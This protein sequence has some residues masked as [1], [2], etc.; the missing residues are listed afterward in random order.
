V[1]LAVGYR[2]VWRRYIIGAGA[3][4]SM[5]VGSEI[6]T[7]ISFYFLGRFDNPLFLKRDKYD[8]KC[9]ANAC[10]VPGSSLPGVNSLP[11]LWFL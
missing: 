2:M 3:Y 6:H 10:S 7:C 8:E 11:L 9:Y 1:D 4:H 5:N